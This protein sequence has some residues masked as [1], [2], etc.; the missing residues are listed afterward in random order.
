MSTSIRIV[1]IENSYT[2]KCEHPDCTF[3]EIE[4]KISKAVAHSLANPG[5]TTET[6]HIVVSKAGTDV[7]LTN[8][9]DPDSSNEA[10]AGS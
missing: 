8:P 9:S 7:A 10:A 3:K 1:T 2:S 4:V 5:H 6:A